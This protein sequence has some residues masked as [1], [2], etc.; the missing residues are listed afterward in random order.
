MLTTRRC[1]WG[2]RGR[3]GL[4]S[5]A[6]RRGG[7]RRGRHGRRHGDRC[8]GRRHRVGRRGAHLL[9]Q[10]VERD[11]AGAV[12]LGAQRDAVAEDI[13]GQHPLGPYGGLQHL[14]FLG[15]ALAALDIE[16]VLVVEA[17]QQPAAGAGDLRRIE[18]EVLVLGDGEVDRPQLGKPAG[19]AILPAAAA[20]AGEP[21][22]LVARPD[23]AQLDARPE[24]GG[25]V[26]HQGAEIHPLL[27]REVQRELA[28]IPLPRGVGDLHRQVVRPDPVASRAPRR[29]FLGVQLLGL[30]HVGGG[31]AAQHVA[32]HRR[33]DIGKR[34][35][36]AAARTL[37]EGHLAEGRHAAQVLA[38]LDLDDDGVVESQGLGRI[39]VEVLLPVA[40]E[41]HLDDRAHFSLRAPIERYFSSRRFR[42]LSILTRRSSRTWR[43]SDSPSACAV[44]SGSAWAPPGG[45][46]RI[47]SITPSRRR[48]WA[49]SL[50]ASAARSRWLASFHRMAAQPSGVITEYTEFSSINTR[51]ASPTASAPP[52]P[53]SPITAAMVGVRN[54]AI[55]SRLRAM[56]SAWPRS[57][58]AR[59]GYAPG[60]ST[61]V[62]TGAWNFSASRIRRIA[63]R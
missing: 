33:G 9:V 28:A 29:V 44:A 10:P 51:S 43:R 8:C 4:G 57:S 3:R 56:A 53:P 6:R 41:P 30:L 21:S 34:A 26:A 40:L 38:P 17:A 12:V 14:P 39:P 48:S 42:S 61:S 46:G 13:H 1:G 58:A 27:G 5:L 32:L 63:L 20:D 19:A 31:G 54:D 36:A 60:V 22:R 59:P 25:E 7:G 24:D 16:V 11:D 45:S 52:E 37:L 49:V 2:R 18:R 15:E 23:L 55:T 47:S 50:S 62:I 35:A